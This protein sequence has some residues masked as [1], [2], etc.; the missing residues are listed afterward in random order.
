MAEINNQQQW[1]IHN[2]V[3]KCIIL[4]FVLFLIKFT[5]SVKAFRKPKLMLT[6]Q[7]FYDITTESP[8]ALTP[9]PISLQLEKCSLRSMGNSKLVISIKSAMFSK[10]YN[11]GDICYGNRQCGNHANKQ[12][13]CS[14]H[15]H[16]N[17]QSQAS[18]QLHHSYCNIEIETH[19]K[20]VY[21]NLAQRCNDRK[22]CIIDDFHSVSLVGLCESSASGRISAYENS[23]GMSV[24]IHECSECWARQVH[25]YYD[26]VQQRSNA[27]Q[28]LN[29]QIYCLSL[30]AC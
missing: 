4:T 6:S 25:V 1:N 27:G 5:F 19:F 14:N 8:Y 18:K 13:C 15:Q 10:L 17:N 26:C 22:M 11:S 9:E 28:C 7:C 23:S 3:R 21:V 29:M 24:G 12:C 20:F 16:S 30:C 2:H